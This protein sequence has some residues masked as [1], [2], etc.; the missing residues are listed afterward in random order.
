[1]QTKCTAPFFD[2]ASQAVSVSV[3]NVRNATVVISPEAIAN[4]R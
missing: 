1:M 2:T 4:S 3:R